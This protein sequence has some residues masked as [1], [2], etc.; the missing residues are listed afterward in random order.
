MH[1]YIVVQFY[2]WFKFLFPLFQIHYHTLQ[3][4]KTKKKQKKN[5]EP[6][7]KLNHNRYFSEKLLSGHYCEWK[8][9][10]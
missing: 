3:Y 2:P 7:I 1:E 8:G 9:R 10:G 4:P 6:R 5:F